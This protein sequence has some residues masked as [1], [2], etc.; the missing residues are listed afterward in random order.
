MTVHVLGGT[1]DFE[2]N[3]GGMAF[4]E[5]MHQMPWVQEL[6]IVFIGPESGMQDARE[7]RMDCC[8]KCSGAGRKRTY[9]VSK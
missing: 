2:M 6:V 3:Y 1:V 7:I 9:A 5:L 8:P 4:E